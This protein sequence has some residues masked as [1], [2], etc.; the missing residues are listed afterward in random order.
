MFLVISNC[1]VAHDPIATYCNHLFTQGYD[2][3]LR[4]ATLFFSR[5]APTHQHPANTCT[6]K[7]SNIDSLF[8][9]QVGPLIR[10]HQLPQHRSVMRQRRLVRSQHCE[11]NLQYFCPA[12]LRT[13]STPHWSPRTPLSTT[14]SDS[15]DKDKSTMSELEQS[16]TPTIPVVR[17]RQRY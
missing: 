15:T 16:Q 8:T 3:N 5:C 9:A 13:P 6:Y 1:F 14:S 7:S 11:H 2:A 4:V 10:S 17:Q 12:L